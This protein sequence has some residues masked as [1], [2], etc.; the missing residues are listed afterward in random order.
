[1]RDDAPGPG[2]DFFTF[3]GA[4]PPAGVTLTVMRSKDVFFGLK[5]D[6]LG[7]GP[8]VEEDTASLS[9]RYFCDDDGD[10]LDDG[11]PGVADAIVILRSA[12]GEIVDRTTTDENGLYSFD[13]LL[14]GDYVVEFSRDTEPGKRFV[15]P[16]SGDGTNDSDVIDLDA[17]LTGIIT[18]RDGQ[19]ERNV[20]AGITY[21]DTAPD[22]FV[23]SDALSTSNDFFL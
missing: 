12:D 3:F 10:G 1:M 19:D 15:A 9:G 21:A 2:D 17:G 6:K 20:D 23:F 14:A 22:D 5:Y 13:D 11:D 16:S 18:L 7:A 8:E 4:V